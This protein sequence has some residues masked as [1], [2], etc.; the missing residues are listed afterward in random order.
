MRRSCWRMPASRSAAPRSV[1]SC[2][3]CF[4]AC[5]QAAA[6]QLPPHVY[7]AK[8]GF[9]MCRATA[10]GVRPNALVA[11][12]SKLASTHMSEVRSAL[13]DV[14]Q[15]AAAQQQGFCT[16][17]SRR[18]GSRRTTSSA[19]FASRTRASAMYSRACCKSMMCFLIASQPAN[20][21][22]GACSSCLVAMSRGDLGP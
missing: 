13:M 16:L 7:V 22:R 17:T 2:C 8:G 10:T 15:P 6:G 14:Y 12:L 9:G 1:L 4:S 19:S 5:T 21:A 18:R 11:A 20:I 3:M